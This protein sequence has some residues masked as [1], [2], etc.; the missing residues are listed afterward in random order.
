[1]DFNLAAFSTEDLTKLLEAKL[2]KPQTE[3]MVQTI[4]AIRG[5]LQS[6]EEK[7]K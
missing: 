6:R 7:S 4:E 5:E 3:V 1:M 2:K